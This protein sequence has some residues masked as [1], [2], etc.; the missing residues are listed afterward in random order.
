MAATALASMA[1]SL[2]RILL[3]GNVDDLAPQSLRLLA[4]SAVYLAA[5][6]VASTGPQLKARRL[7]ERAGTADPDRRRRPNRL[8]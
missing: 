5:G 4:F 3:P 8:G 1:L 6:R 7:R 2:L